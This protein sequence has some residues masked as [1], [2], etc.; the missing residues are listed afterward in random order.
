[1][2]FHLWKQSLLHSIKELQSIIILYIKPD[3]IPKNNNNIE[4][5]CDMYGFQQ[6]SPYGQPMYGAPMAPPMVQPM[7]MPPAPAPAG[8]TI[9]NISSGKQEGS[10]CPACGEH[11]ESVQRKDA[12]CAT[13]S[14]CICLAL[15]VTP[16]FFIPFCTDSCKDT[17]IVCVKCQSI[18]TTVKGQCC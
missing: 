3:K 2:I 12:G 16:L 10:K 9:I 4:F 13:W 5:T 1:M 7:Y 17:E 6:P 11:S 15:T 8:P 18:K 14:W